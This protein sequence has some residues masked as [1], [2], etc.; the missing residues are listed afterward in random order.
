MLNEETWARNVRGESARP[1]KGGAST[2]EVRDATRLFL[3]VPSPKANHSDKYDEAELEIT[4]KMQDG[5]WKRRLPRPRR[6]NRI[7]GFTAERWGDLEKRKKGKGSM[8]SS[9]AE[10]PLRQR[11]LSPPQ[12]ERRY[13]SVV[14][15]APRLHSRMAY[16]LSTSEMSLLRRRFR[17][18]DAIQL[19]K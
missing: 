1:R 19:E 14:V 11:E 18:H 17:Y 12:R 13:S 7:R 16:F 5:A 2:E 8:S 10:G 9:L 4:R 6:K 3:R 15:E